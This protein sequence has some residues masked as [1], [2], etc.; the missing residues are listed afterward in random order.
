MW[1]TLIAVIGT[2][3]GVLI[4]ALAQGR[5]A[6][7]SLDGAEATARRQAAVD[8]VADLVAAIAA[9]RA[10]M[11]HR[12]TLRLDGAD[13]TD[14]RQHSQTTRA[15]I[16]APAVKVAVLLPALRDAADAAAQASYALRGAETRNALDAARTASLTA[17][18]RLIT[19]AGRL[20]GA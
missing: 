20:L 13:W 17:D 6:R 1:T 12:E 19:D 16:S 18:E 5:T 3:A 14:A 11:W 8:S 7:R 10:A 4:A 2:L 9:H 15:A